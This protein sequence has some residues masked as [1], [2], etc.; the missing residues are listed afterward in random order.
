VDVDAYLERIGYE[1]SRRPT[2]E[3]LAALQRAHMLTVP[4]EN[5]EIARGGKLVLDREHNFDK[6]VR[7]RRGGWCFELNGLFAGL[8]EE[9]GFTVAMLGSSVIDEDGQESEDLVHL[10]LLVDLEEPLITDVGFGE[11]SI[12]PI[13]PDT[14]CEITNGGLRVRYSLRPRTIDAFAGQCERLQTSP[15]SPFV[16][17][18]MCSMALPDGRLTLSDLRLIETRNGVRT[19]RVLSGEDEWRQVLRDRFGVVLDD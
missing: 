9:L 6:V 15:D 18:R 3:T 7:R 5:L 14:G 10:L 1:G 19:E 16:Q 11:S 12:E 2:A 17:K 8:L 13:P 4:F